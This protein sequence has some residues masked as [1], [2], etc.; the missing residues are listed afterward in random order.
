MNDQLEIHPRF[1]MK[2]DGLWKRFHRVGR[3]TCGDAWKD[4]RAALCGFVTRGRTASSKKLYPYEMK[5]IIDHLEVEK[6]VFS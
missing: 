3:A 4:R 1:V 2:Q 6:E 5:A